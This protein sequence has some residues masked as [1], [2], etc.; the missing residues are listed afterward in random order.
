MR[1]IVW[2]DRFLEPDGQ[3]GEYWVRFYEI[4]GQVVLGFTASIATVFQGVEIPQGMV[5]NWD[6]KKLHSPD[7][8]MA[9]AAN[10]VYHNVSQ[11]KPWSKKAYP[12]GLPVFPKGIFPEGLEPD[13]ESESDPEPDSDLSIDEQLADLEGIPEIWLKD[14]LARYPEKEL[15]QG[16][17]PTAP[18]VSQ[19]FGQQPYR[20]PIRVPYTKESVALTRGF[21]D[22]PLMVEGWTAALQQACID[23]GVDPGVAFMIAGHFLQ[24]CFNAF[25]VELPEEELE[26][27]E[28]RPNIEEFTRLINSE[29]GLE[30]DDEVIKKLFEDP[31]EE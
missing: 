10:D 16:I 1:D 22:N 8:I 30:A 11:I 17:W 23:K 19:A 9:L 28:L 26:G 7:Q 21:N 4:D 31:T 14:L 6:T 5:F 15:L 24:E 2:G 3:E 12:K 18:D 20:K 29:A 13:P 27:L 25:Y